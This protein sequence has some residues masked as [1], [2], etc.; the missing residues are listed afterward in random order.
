MVGGYPRL[1][2]EKAILGY[3]P[4]QPFSMWLRGTSGS[5]RVR[6]YMRVSAAGLQPATIPIRRQTLLFLLRV[7]VQHPLLHLHRWY[8]S[9]GLFCLL[10]TGCEHAYHY[11]TSRPEKGVYN[12]ISLYL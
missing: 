10:E 7:E 4:T 5:G 9:T 11:R 1:I 2:T 6:T 3:D 8:I 12:R